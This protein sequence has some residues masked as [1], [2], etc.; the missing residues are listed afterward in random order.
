MATDNKNFTSEYTAP[1]TALSIVPNRIS[2]C[3]DLRGPSVT[4]DTGFLKNFFFLF[5]KTLLSKKGN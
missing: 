3:L 2:Y 1:G 4:V 5:K